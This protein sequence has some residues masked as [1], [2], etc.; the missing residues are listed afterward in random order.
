MI[1][2]FL[3][4]IFT[5]SVMS[6]GSGSLG[7]SKELNAANTGKEIVSING[8]SI[9]DG[10]VNML[11][12][13]NPRIKAQLSNPAT[14]KQLIA[15]VVEQE[16]MYQ[17]SL[18]RGIDKKKDVAQKAAL[19]KKIIIAQ[20][21]VDDELT[22]KIKKYYEE[23][24]DEEFTKVKISVIAVNF[25]ADEAK[26]DGKEDKKADVKPADVNQQQKEAALNKIKLVQTRIKGGE[27]F[28]KV[29]EE[30]SD[31]KASQKKGGD[32]G[33]ISKND[34]RLAR[35]NLEK[36]GEAAF[37]LKKDEV[38]EPIEGKTAYY[39]IKV[40]SD[41]EVTPF[42]DA[43]KLLR[44]QLQKDVKDELVSKLTKASN[45][46]YADGEKPD[47]NSDPH[48]IL[49]QDIPASAPNGGASGAPEVQQEKTQTE[50]SDNQFK[51]VLKTETPDDK[52]HE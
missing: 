40:M 37:T 39:I 30:V 8:T 26:K 21:L 3:A 44:F 7:D 43:E 4:L 35:R 29:A 46:K 48:Q 15:S 50:P 34:K 10:Y 11:A 31:D 27:A 24:R 38:S 25:V 14:K 9:K 36:L 5:V 28:A 33:L 1:R 13:I 19:Y 52:K 23:K 20:A 17:E 12:E 51:P 32:F 47:A 6:C 22:E 49:K 2:Y 45:I 18:K 16:L 41:P 42:A